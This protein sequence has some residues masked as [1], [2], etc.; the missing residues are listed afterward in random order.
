MD[1]HN[2]RRLCAA[3]L[4]ALLLLTQAALCAAE[5]TPTPASV[6]KDAI[7]PRPAVLPPEDIEPLPAVLAGKLEPPCGAI[8]FAPTFAFSQ[9]LRLTIDNAACARVYVRAYRGTV[10]AADGDGWYWPARGVLQE[11]GSLSRD[12]AWKMKNVRQ[13]DQ[14]EFL[15]APRPSMIWDVVFIFYLDAEL[16]VL[17]T[18]YLMVEQNESGEYAIGRLIM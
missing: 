4:L 18:Q 8:D 1:T 11:D 16:A 14:V 2:Q 15:Y 9:S 12:I 17:D 10:V 5:S 13:G 6:L 7:E 3:L